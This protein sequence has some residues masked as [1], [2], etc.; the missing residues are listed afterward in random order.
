[1]GRLFPIK[2]YR[3]IRRDIDGN[4]INT[5][6]MGGLDLTA[7]V[8]CKPCNE[9]WM[10]DIESKYAQP[11]MEA[12]IIGGKTDFTI[13]KA[14]AKAIALFAFKTAVVIDHMGG[15]PPSLGDL[16]VTLLRRNRLFPPTFKCGLLDFFR[17][18]AEESTRIIARR[19]FLNRDGSSSTYALIWSAI[20]CFKWFVPGIVRSP[21]LVLRR[22]LN[23][24][25]YRFGR[26]SRK[27][28]AGRLPMS[29][30][31]RPTLCGFLRD[32]EFLVLGRLE[33]RRFGNMP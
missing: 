25:L 28:F 23:T 17:W 3:F 26:D 31:L 5:F 7:N 15:D 10:S 2:K 4:A 6:S 21:L 14:R 19:P 24:W 33:V 22:V 9:G 11:A 1:M 16:F 30:G 32:G 29:S 27:T 8:V 20:L 13:S 18:P 12:L